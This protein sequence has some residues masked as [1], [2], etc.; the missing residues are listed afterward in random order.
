M[1]TESWWRYYWLCP[2]HTPTSFWSPWTQKSQDSGEE[3]TLLLSHLVMLYYNSKFSTWLAYSSRLFVVS[4]S[5]VRSFGNNSGLNFQTLVTGF[6]IVMQV[7]PNF[8]PEGRTFGESKISSNSKPLT[9]LWH[10]SGRCPEDTIPIRRTKKDDILRA[11]SIQQ[12]GKKK[13]RSFP[14]P[15]SA[16]A[17]PLPDLITQSGHQVLPLPW[18]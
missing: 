2:C 3:F 6:V 14:Q 16:K 10:K 12:F 11:S 7:R 1:K 13:Q 4:F 15:K 5:F 8:H 9:Q 18:Y 17:K